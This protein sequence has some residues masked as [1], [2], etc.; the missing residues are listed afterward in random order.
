MLTVAVDPEQ[1]TRMAQDCEDDMS[2]SRVAD[3]YSV[4]QSS[5]SKYVLT[6][7]RQS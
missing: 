7:R 1:V 5:V 2:Q 3:K 6:A 4:S